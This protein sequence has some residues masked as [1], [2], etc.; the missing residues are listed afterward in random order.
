MELEVSYVI[1]CPLAVF[2]SWLAFPPLSTVFSLNGDVGTGRL[3]F[4]KIEM[5]ENIKKRKMNLKL[6]L[7]AQ[8]FIN[9]Q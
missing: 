4:K 8:S 1:F 9:I 5:Q 6:F 7:W 2:Y 3:A